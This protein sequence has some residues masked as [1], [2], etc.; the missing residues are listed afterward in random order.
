MLIKRYRF[1]SN[2]NSDLKNNREAGA[3][4]THIL[5]NPSLNFSLFNGFEITNFKG[6]KN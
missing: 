2:A 3:I 6:S 5:E 4:I 1:N